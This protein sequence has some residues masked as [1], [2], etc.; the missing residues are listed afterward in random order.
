MSIKKMTTIAMLTA[1]YVVLSILTPIRIINFK[2]TF[3]AFPILVAGLLLGPLEGLL[4]GTLGS[5]IYQLFFSG[6]GITLTTPLWILPHALSGL[7]CGLCAKRSG[8]DLSLKKTIIICCLSSLIVTSLNML[9]LYLDSK[10]YGYYSAVLVFGNLGLKVVIGILMALIYAA[11]LPKLLTYL[12]IV[13]KQQ[14]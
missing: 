2:L 11:I 13:L 7:F 9:A 6:Y 10:I 12:K 8:F 5:C 3:E 14:A 4:T 1:V